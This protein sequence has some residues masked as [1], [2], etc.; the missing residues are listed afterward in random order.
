MLESTTRLQETNTL[1]HCSST[2]R[3]E[4]TDLP[5][6]SVRRSRSRSRSESCVRFLVCIVRIPYHLTIHQANFETD[7][8]RHLDFTRWVLNNEDLLDQV[9]WIDEA[10]E[11]LLSLNVRSYVSVC[12]TFLDFFSDKN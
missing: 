8:Q 12:K 2:Q 7:K 3:A 6:R 10:D 1:G 11:G 4:V 9:L 5:S